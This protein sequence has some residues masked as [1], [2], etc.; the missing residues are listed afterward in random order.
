MLKDMK[1]SILVLAA[2]VATL[3]LNIPSKATSLDKNE[4]TLPPRLLA[5]SSWVVVKRLD[6]NFSVEMPATP[7]EEITEEKL[8]G[9]EEV[10]VDGS[11]SSLDK[12]KTNTQFFRVNYTRASY[13]GTFLFSNKKMLDDLSLGNLTEVGKA[14]LF[15]QGGTS[16]SL[17]AKYEK[18]NNYPGREYR[19]VTPDGVFVLRLYGVEDRIFIVTALYPKQE[20]VDRFINSF[21][22]NW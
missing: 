22:I 20:D 7:T 14:H 11:L 18:Y 19:E 4:R 17:R 3:G 13:I 2:L 6:E 12:G 1:S 15:K 9:I 21:T 8:P 10:L 16:I 5:Q